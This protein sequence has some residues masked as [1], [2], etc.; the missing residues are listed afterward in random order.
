[1]YLLLAFRRS[2]LLP[3]SEDY[4]EVVGS[5]IIRNESFI[6]LNDG[7]FLQGITASRGGGRMVTRP[8]SY[9]DNPM[10]ETRP[11]GRMC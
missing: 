10:F 2:L 3:S 5:K 4:R 7:V 11:R 9:S 6:L 8:Y 1:M